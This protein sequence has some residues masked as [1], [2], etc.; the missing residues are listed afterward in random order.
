MADGLILKVP[1]ELNPAVFKN[2]SIGSLANYSACHATA[3][4]GIDDDDD[5]KIPR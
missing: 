5:I 2:E 1:Y 3:E 4:K